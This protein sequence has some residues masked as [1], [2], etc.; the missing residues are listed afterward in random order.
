MAVLRASVL[1]SAVMLLSGCR[2]GP[3]QWGPFR[4]QVVDA[5]TGMPIAGAHVMVTWIREPPSLHFSQWFYDAQEAA[6][7]RAGRFEIPRQT[8]FATAFVI[9]PGISVFMPGYLM[10]A[11][12]V[13]PA[14]GR[15]YVE[16][17]IVKMRPLKTREERCK[18]R[19][20]GPWIDASPKV[21]RFKAAIQQYNVSLKCWEL[22]E[23]QR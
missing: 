12:D 2:G 20:G 7:D 18:L 14:T 5:E 3:E 6:T 1:L 4:G 13:T 22:V 21:P 16:P 11:P 8:R 10:Q 17:T 15:A 9:E 19:P 23:G